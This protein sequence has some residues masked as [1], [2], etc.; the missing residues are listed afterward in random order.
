M[1]KRN[2]IHITGKHLSIKRYNQEQ[3]KWLSRIQHKSKLRIYKTFKTKLKFEII[4]MV[5]LYTQ[6]CGMDQITLKLKKVDGT[7][8]KLNREYVNIVIV[9]KLKMKHILF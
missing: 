9:S 4:I 8:Y 5:V 2:R 1:E 7:R 3:K 6:V